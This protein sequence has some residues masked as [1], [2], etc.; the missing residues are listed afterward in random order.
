M[1]GEA[2]NI[3]LQQEAEI[4]AI[5]FS[6]G[7]VPTDDE[8]ASAVLAGDEHAFAE[9]FERYRRPVTR[10]VSRFFRD[11]GEIEEMVQQSF[12]KAYFSL[13][14][15]RGGQ[16]SSF[17]AWMTKIAV[18]VCYDEF[19]RR[20][21][22][23]ESRFSEL[24]D[25]AANYIET[26]SDTRA[27]ASDTTIAAADLVER[28]MASVDPLDRIALTLVYSEEYSLYDVA[29]FLGIP[30]SNLKSRLFRCRNHIK[31]RFKHLLA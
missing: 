27:V 29:N 10:V 6:D 1:L 18:N 17:A 4:G 9:I 30:T 24:D 15:Y 20:G 21:R 2:L 22:R 3:P 26:V 25:A 7:V 5:T 23:G 12:T 13:K 19:R 14:K 11:R 16:S 31:K 28:I 8:L